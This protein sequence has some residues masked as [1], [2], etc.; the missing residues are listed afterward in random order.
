[1]RNMA[2][3][4]NNEERLERLMNRLAESVLEL[5]DETVLAEVNESGTDPAQEAETTRLVLRQASKNFDSLEKRLCNLGH[6]I[7]SNDWHY[8]DGTYDNYCLSCGAWVSFETA[9]GE[10]QGE[11]FDRSCFGNAYL[12]KRQEASR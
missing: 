6:A 8:V 4:K 11:A 7:D 2:D 9:T 3:K 10:I 1:M 12:I 5:S